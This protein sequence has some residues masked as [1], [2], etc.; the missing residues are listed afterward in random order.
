MDKCR[1]DAI[2]VSSYIDSSIVIKVHSNVTS[3]SG[4][5]Y[6]LSNGQIKL[7]DISITVSGNIN[8]NIDVVKLK[9]YSTVT[10]DRITKF[11]S[12]GATTRGVVLKEYASSGI[13]ALQANSIDYYSI[14][15]GTTNI[16]FTNQ[17]FQIPYR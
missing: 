9:Y 5:A 1:Y 11:S 6:I 12:T 15:S 16:D 8:T 2:S 13:I 7:K 3:C 10:S 4:S 17:P 14:S